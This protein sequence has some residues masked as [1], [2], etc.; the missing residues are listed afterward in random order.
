[1]EKITNSNLKKYGTNCTLQNDEIKEKSKKTMLEKYGVFNPMLNEEIKEKAEKTKLDKF[2]HS[3]MFKTSHFIDETKKTN[4]EK[5]GTEHS[6]ANYAMK[7]FVWKSGE[8]AKVQGYES[9][10]LTEL[11]EQG[12]NFNDVITDR[13][14]IPKF[15]Y[16]FEGM[17][18]TYYPDFYIPS[19]NLII[20]VKSEWTL[21]AQLE[22]NKAK[23]EAVKEAGYNF[24]L[25][26]R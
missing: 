12:Y 11:E 15:T 25:E 10:V 1:M 2:G 16:I 21:Q 6:P 5:Y 18:K 22:K 13:K 26:I 19:E 3:N 7:E 23:F 4:L 8:V 24:R 14:S 17:K 20:E 9:I